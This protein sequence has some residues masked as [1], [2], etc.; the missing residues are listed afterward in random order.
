MKDDFIKIA[1]LFVKVGEWEPTWVHISLIKTT[2][3]SWFTC[4]W[5]FHILMLIPWAPWRTLRS[6]FLC[7]VVVID[8]KLLPLLFLLTSMYQMRG[9][10]CYSSWLCLPWPQS[11]EDPSQPAW[12]HGRYTTFYSSCFSAC[13][14]DSLTSQQGTFQFSCWLFRQFTIITLCL[15]MK[16]CSLQTSLASQVCVCV[17]RHHICS[18]N[19]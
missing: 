18:C 14:M 7:L 8:Q 2:E 6:L 13:P 19:I 4:I 16:L 9:G 15:L 1:R 17:H 3:S 11:T 10:V 5:V 12:V